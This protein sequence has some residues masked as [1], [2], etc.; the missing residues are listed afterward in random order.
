MAVPQLCKTQQA[1]LGFVVSLLATEPLQVM[2]HWAG[3]FTHLVPALLSEAVVLLRVVT[4]W[5]RQMYQSVPLLHTAL[6]ALGNPG[7][8]EMAA[9]STAEFRALAFPA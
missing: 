5:H 1:A 6:L 3:D 4:P 9:S 2:S 7:Q 8:Q